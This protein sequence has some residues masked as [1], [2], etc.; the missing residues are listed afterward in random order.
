MRRKE[1]TLSTR[2]GAIYFNVIRTLFGG[3][4]VHA[5]Y[6]YWAESIG[7]FEKKKKKHVDDDNESRKLPSST[8]AR[9]G[10]TA[11]RGR[12]PIQQ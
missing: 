10:S 4:K 1:K 5:R 3:R 11:V 9:T 7:R 8:A 2:T 12:L 6:G